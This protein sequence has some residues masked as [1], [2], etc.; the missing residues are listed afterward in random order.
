MQQQK[1]FLCYMVILS[2]EVGLWEQGTLHFK[3][4]FSGNTI[5][6]SIENVITLFNQSLL[7]IEL[8]WRG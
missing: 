5:F 6:T 4:A 2:Y 7:K 8:T 1:S 3:L